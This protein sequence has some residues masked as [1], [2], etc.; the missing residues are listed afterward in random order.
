MTSPVFHVINGDNLVMTSYVL[1]L[2]EKVGLA[3]KNLLGQLLDWVTLRTEI[4]RFPRV[5]FFWP[6][7]SSSHCVKLSDWFIDVS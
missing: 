5:T 7:G 1:N 3:K 2:R 4:S 6:N